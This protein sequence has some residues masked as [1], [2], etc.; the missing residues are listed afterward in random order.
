MAPR[1]LPAI[2]IIAPVAAASGPAAVLAALI[3]VNVGPNLTY[4]GSLATLLRRRLLRADGAD[5]HLGEFL[6]LGAATVAAALAASTL[7]L[8]SGLQ[9][10]L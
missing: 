5:V 10:G 8:W 2:L 4:A 3:G 6:R 1:R 9:T 7:M